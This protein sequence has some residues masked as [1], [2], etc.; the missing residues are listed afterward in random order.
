MGHHPALLSERIT[1]PGG[2]SAAA[3]HACERGKLR[4]VLSDSVWAAYRR[5]LEMGQRNSNLGPGRFQ[6]TG[7]ASLTDDT[8]K[9]LHDLVEVQQQLVQ[10]T[11]NEAENEEQ[12]TA[13][14]DDSAPTQA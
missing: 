2:T 14:T 12:D 9:T 5:S 8:L 13:A 3:L 7:S 4:S 10:L 11:N 1:S 6:R